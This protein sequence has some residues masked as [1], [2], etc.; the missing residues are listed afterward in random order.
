MEISI[1]FPRPAESVIRKA[2]VRLEASGIISKIY[3]LVVVNTTASI[4]GKTYAFD[5]N[6]VASEKQDSGKD[7]NDSSI[8]FTWYD[9]KRGRNFTIMKEL[10][11]HPGVA[12]GTK[13]DLDI[14]A[15]V[16]EAEA[17]DQGIAG[18]KAVALCLLN[19]TLDKEFPSSVRYVL[20]QG[21]TFPQYSVVTNNQLLSL[22]TVQALMKLPSR[23]LTV[24]MLMC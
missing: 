12:D 9:E 7:D 1:I 14:L 2:L 15:A 11:S 5:S 4:G 23:H 17:G 24:L 19:R 13:S 3:F 22:L 20:Y 10:K 6:G 8:T 18:M 21:T 16:C